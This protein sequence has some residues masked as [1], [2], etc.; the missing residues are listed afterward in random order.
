MRGDVM[1]A[2]QKDV[3]AIKMVIAEIDEQIYKLV[4]S[5][6]IIGE[7]DQDRKLIISEDETLP[8]AVKRKRIVDDLLTKKAEFE[9]L[10]E[11]LI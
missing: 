1:Q 5:V 4:A 7:L 9:R 6:K 11:R 10:M 2:T 8:D 3:E